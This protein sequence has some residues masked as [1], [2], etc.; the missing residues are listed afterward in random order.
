VLTAGIVQLAGSG[1]S[2]QLGSYAKA[3]DPQISAVIS[4]CI[5]DLDE[6]ASLYHF[7]TIASNILQYIVDA[8]N[9]E[10]S[11]EKA[12]EMF[13]RH[14][15]GPHRLTAAFPAGNGSNG[16]RLPQDK[17]REF[18]SMHIGSATMLDIANPPFWLFAT[19][20]RPIVDQAQDLEQSGFSML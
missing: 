8:E 15:G 13:R 10:A 14:P 3:S 19:Q 5:A 17:T 9:V 18:T 4:Q 2:N 6:M 20:S 7:A 12:E 11:L 16:S 1:S